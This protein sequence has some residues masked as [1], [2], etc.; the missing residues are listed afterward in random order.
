MAKLDM[1]AL[2]IRDQLYAVD[3]GAGKPWSGTAA[4]LAALSGSD[5]RCVPGALFQLI[6]DGC[7]LSF[8]DD[9]VTFAGIALAAA[10]PERVAPPEP[11][12]AFVQES[13]GVVMS[14]GELADHARRRALARRQEREDALRRAGQLTFADMDFAPEPVAVA[15]RRVPIHAKPERLPVQTAAALRIRPE[16][17][18]SREAQTQA[19]AEA[20]KRSCN[21]APVAPLRRCK[22]EGRIGALLTSIAN[23]VSDPAY[24]SAHT[25]APAPASSKNNNINLNQSIQS[26]NTGITTKEPQIQPEVTRE[27]AKIVIA[28]VAAPRFRKRPVKAVFSE[29]NDELIARFPGL[30]KR[31][32]EQLAYMRAWGGLSDDEY[33]GLTD[34]AERARSPCAWLNSQI[35]KW[36]P[37]K[38]WNKN[39]RFSNEKSTN[40]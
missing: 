17:P 15:P 25:D 22:P 33:E 20:P 32:R 39:W 38:K 36:L 6:N 18:A 10:E 30:C 13:E 19:S 28:T 14:Y 24:I 4:D 27:V 21:E 16:S 37:V 8:K 26:M 29:T 11:V 35:T 31:L 40:N 23:R 7:P 3:K 1:T 12:A 2:K 5:K 9:A 34:D